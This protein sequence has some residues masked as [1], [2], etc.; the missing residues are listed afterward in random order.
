MMIM[1]IAVREHLGNEPLGTVE[2]CEEDLPSLGNTWWQKQ[3]AFSALH[4]QV[5][6]GSKKN[7]KRLRA[8]VSG[9]R[10]FAPSRQAWR[11]KSQAV[12]PS[13]SDFSGVA[14]TLRGFFGF[15]VP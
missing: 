2:R 7:Y 8:P 3:P 13:F 11:S 10:L 15:G 5:Q 1:N 6:D 9:L 12:L 14:P 4:P